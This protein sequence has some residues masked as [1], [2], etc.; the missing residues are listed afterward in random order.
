[1]KQNGG[2]AIVNTGIRTVP[3]PINAPS[4]RCAAQL[5]FGFKLIATL[6]FMIAEI[7]F[8][9][10]LQKKDRDESQNPG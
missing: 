3:D 10:I 7:P 1:M 8:R 6:F 5:F 9:E 4:T 2:D